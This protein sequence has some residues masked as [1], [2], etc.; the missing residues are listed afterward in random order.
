MFPDSDIAQTFNMERKKLSYVISHGLGPFFHR[1]LVEDIRQ[2]E[3][4]VLCFDEQ[5]NYQNNKQLDIIFKYWSVKNQR[6]VTRY[7]K[8][9]LPGHAPAHVIRDHIINSFRTDGIDIKRLLMIGQDNP[10]VN[11]TIEKLIDG[12]MKKV[13][14]EL[15]KLGSCHI[16]VVHNAFKSG[17]NIII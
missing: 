1:N 16:H 7:Y 12:E 5:K 11:K 2:C 8:S 17:E 14:G 9:I 10:N 6:V 3:R 4:F 15:L 13:G